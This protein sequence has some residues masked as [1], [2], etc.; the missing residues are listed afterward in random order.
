MDLLALDQEITLAING[1]NSP[2]ADE[3]FFI[4]T[5]TDVWLTLLI[6]LLL[7][8]WRECGWRNALMLLVGLALCVFLSD[9]FCSIIKHFVCRLRP[10]HE[11][12]LDGLVHIVHD[13]TGGA[14]GFC[15]A[16]AANTVAVVV[17][18][19]LLL[20]RTP[21][22]VAMASWSVLSMWSRMYLGVHYLGDIV[23][24][25]LLGAAIAVGI[26]YLYRF[27]V[28]K[29]GAEQTVKLKRGGTITVIACYLAVVALIALVAWTRV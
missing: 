5:R 7:V 12:E 26:Y 11:P 6:V 15:S 16:H 24:G 20:R 2:F 29:M 19:S 17:F 10:T 27:V 28:R 4:F 22:A 13:Y 21:Y 1:W 3:F 23:A 9:Q 8:L 14:Y 25:A 18:S